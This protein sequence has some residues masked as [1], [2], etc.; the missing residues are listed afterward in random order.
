MYTFLNELCSNVNE[1]PLP[2][3]QRDKFL[4]NFKTE[5]RND[6]GKPCKVNP[7]LTNCQYWNRIDGNG[8]DFDLLLQCI[9]LNP[10]F[11]PF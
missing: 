9:N 5:R 4:N 1:S 6:F 2:I 7:I 10:L 11:E 8:N 3:K